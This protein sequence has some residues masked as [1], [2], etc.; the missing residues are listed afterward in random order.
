VNRNIQ[1]PIFI[2]T[3]DLRTQTGNDR[4]PF[5]RIQNRSIKFRIQFYQAYMVLR[6][7][8][9][10]SSTTFQRI[11]QTGNRSSDTNPSWLTTLLTMLKTAL[12]LHRCKG[13][14]RDTAVVLVRSAVPG[15]GGRFSF[16]TIAPLCSGTVVGVSLHRLVSVGV[17]HRFGGLRLRFD[18][19]MRISK[20][21]RSF[22]LSYLW[23]SRRTGKLVVRYL[24]EILDDRRR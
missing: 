1:Q 8:S 24:G 9:T 4:I 20:L 18:V 6:L 10:A 16:T 3:I 17:R 19:G 15:A 12:P 22:G 14:A 11:I 21:S 5:E 2:S 13:A 23:K 7:P